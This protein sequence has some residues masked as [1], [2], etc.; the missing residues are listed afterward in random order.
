[1]N[2]TE[3]FIDCKE[4]VTVALLISYSRKLDKG[5]QRLSGLK[6]A[7]HVGTSEG[8]YPFARNRSGRGQHSVRSGFRTAG[9]PWSWRLPPLTGGGSIIVDTAITKVKMSLTT[10]ATSDIGLSISGPPQRI[11]GQTNVMYPFR[12]PGSTPFST[13]SQ[14]YYSFISDKKSRHHVNF[15]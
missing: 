5:I 13:V 6:G 9:E 15:L 3:K 2:I 8:L 1:M 7:I 14:R 12:G 10:D 4:H 11:H